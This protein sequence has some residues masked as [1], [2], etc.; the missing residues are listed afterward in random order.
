[1]LFLSFGC[2]CDGSI[3][4]WSTEPCDQLQSLIESHLRRMR[5]LLM[6]ADRFDLLHIES[7]AVEGLTE[8]LGVG[9]QPCRRAR[10][11]RR[12]WGA[13]PAC[14]GSACSRVRVAIFAPWR[15]NA[16]VRVVTALPSAQSARLGCHARSG[17]ARSA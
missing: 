2:E 4:V 11:R 16:V 1:M 9:V 5:A 15:V 10:R 6:L 14:L 12:L 17:A 7:E 3:A 13:G 8:G